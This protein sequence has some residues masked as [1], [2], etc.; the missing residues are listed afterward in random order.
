MAFLRHA[1]L[2]SVLIGCPLFAQ[3]TPKPIG[4]TLEQFQAMG[5]DRLLDRDADGDGKIS[6][7]EF[8]TAAPAHKARVAKAN[9]DADMPA[10]GAPA[11]GGGMMA[12]RTG[13]R[14]FQ[15]FDTNGDGYL[16]KAEIDAMLAQRFQRMDLNHD[17]ILTAEERKAAHGGGMR[18]QTSPGQ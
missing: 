13:D 10:S 5:R 6:N 15:R 2:I 17:G 12:G 3:P 16:D 7:A 1:A 9:V 8:E 4:M 11:M 18:G 14:V